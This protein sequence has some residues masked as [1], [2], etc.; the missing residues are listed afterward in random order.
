MDVDGSVSKLVQGTRDYSLSRNRYVR[1][2][3]L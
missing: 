2:E 1:I 3:Y